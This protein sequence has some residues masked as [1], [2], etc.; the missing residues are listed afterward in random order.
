MFAVVQQLFHLL[1][2]AIIPVWGQPIP[3]LKMK[4]TLILFIFLLRLAAPNTPL[5][6]QTKPYAEL[7]WKNVEPGDIIG[8]AGLAIADLNL[9]MPINQV[10]IKCVGAALCI[11]MAFNGFWWLKWMRMKTP[12]F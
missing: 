1:S 7:I 9:F 4:N 12:I 2:I 6:A 8:G 11:P 3:L 5:G 10:P